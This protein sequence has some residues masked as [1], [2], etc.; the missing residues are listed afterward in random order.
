M[1]RK[2]KAKTDDAQWNQR[3]KLIEEYAALDQEITNFKPR[4]FRHG[5]LRELILDWYPAAAPEEEITI[6]GI[7]CDILISARDKVRAVTEEGK[8]Q[9]YRLWGAKDFIAK[10]Q[11]LLKSLPDPKDEAGL[12]TV[13][14]L[15]G[16]RHLRVVG[17]AQR[18]AANTA[19]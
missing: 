5:K 18:A 16:P 13:Q 11:V 8:K 10:S 1:A 9:L 2:A 4:L 3:L 7:N 14:A 12:Y 19:A 15:S 6:P 17:K